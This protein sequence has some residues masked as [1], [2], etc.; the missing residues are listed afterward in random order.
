MDAACVVGDLE[1]AGLHQDAIAY[2]H[3]GIA[4]DAR[5]WDPKLVDFVV[6]DALTRGDDQQA[7]ALR[8]EW[9]ERFPTSRSF[10]ML[11]DTAE[12][13]VLWPAE[14]EAA[15]RRLA[16]RD[17]PG[18]ATYLLNDDWRRVNIAGCVIPQRP[19]ENHLRGH[20][21]QEGFGTE[22]R[23]RRVD[24]D[25]VSATVVPESIVFRTVTRGTAHRGAFW[26]E[27]RCGIW[28]GKTP[29]RCSPSMTAGSLMS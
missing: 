24:V 12:Q 21:A 9:F 2:A 18:F 16:E 5:G 15:E 17:A 1:E 29:A 14:R 6:D 11:R 20:T 3:T 10:T 25:A 19:S 27:S 22:F 28:L 23:A 13:A 4:M 7:V 8:R 26:H